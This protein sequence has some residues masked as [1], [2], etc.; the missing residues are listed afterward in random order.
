MPSP[1]R[2]HR[3]LAAALPV[4]NIDTDQIIPSRE[5]K[6]VSR[7]GLGEGLFAGWRYT[8]PGG[9][10]PVADF[11]LNRPE[12]A[13]TSILISG[14]NF[15]CGSSREHA[16]WALMDYGVRAVIAKSFGEIFHGN[17]LRNGILPVTLP[18]EDIDRLIA[19]ASGGEIMIDLAAQTVTAGALPGW[20][21]HFEIGAYSKRLLLEGLDPIGLTL[22][23]APSISAFQEADARARPWVYSAG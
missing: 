14:S 15:G 16:V 7:D 20:T 22:L 2:H 9:R 18:E 3:G 5:M 23:Q 1:F 10:E 4:D 12:Q 11:V 19:Q 6:T 17:C 21:G 8:E 13:G